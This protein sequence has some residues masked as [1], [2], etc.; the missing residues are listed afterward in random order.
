[1]KVKT[2]LFIVLLSLPLLSASFTTQVH[3]RQ[4]E[5]QQTRFSPQGSGLIYLLTAQKIHFSLGEPVFFQLKVINPTSQPITITFSG[6]FYRDYE[7]KGPPIGSYR[8][9]QTTGGLGHCMVWDV[10]LAAGDT[11][12]NDFTHY[13]H[14][15]FLPPGLYQIHAWLIGNGD[16]YL[17]IVVGAPLLI[18]VP[19]L[20]VFCM[21][22]VGIILR[23]KSSKKD[24]KANEL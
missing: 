23:L 7:I 4:A 24:S 9:S 21:I 5:P 14:Y 15:Q 10:V 22:V 20:T 13:P 18:A 19:L 6:G 3:P 16:A 11:W 1:M 8:L 17:W 2:L 12:S